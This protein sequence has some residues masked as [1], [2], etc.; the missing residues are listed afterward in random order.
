MTE[1]PAVSWLKTAY[2]EYLQANSTITYAL[3]TVVAVVFLVE[4]VLTAVIGLQSVQV[5]ATGLFGLYPWIAWSFL[6]VLH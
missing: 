6:P 4:V 3:L 1:N 5:F 2:Q